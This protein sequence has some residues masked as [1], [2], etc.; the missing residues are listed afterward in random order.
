MT[1]KTV[2][3]KKEDHIATITMNRPEVYNALDHTLFEDLLGALKEVNADDDV[4]VVILTGAGKAFCSG[5]DLKSKSEGGDALLPNTAIDEGVRYIRHFPQAITRGI[6]QLE[7]PTIAMI[8]GVAVA[9]GFDWVLAC[10]LR[11]ASTNAKFMNAFIRMALFPNTGATWLLPRAIGLTKAFELLY[12]GDWLSAEE[13]NKLGLFNKL[14]APE[15]LEKETMALARK[16]AKQAP[17]PMRMMKRQT[18]QGLETSFDVIL[19]L[20]GDAE[21]ICVKTEDHKA[22]LAAFRAKKEPEFKGK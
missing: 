14:V 2:L 3:L 18:W 17:I 1:G 16:I 5:V 13:A 7:K 4:R 21:M 12:T 20:A 10:D 6:I 9:D 11:V 15:D 22:A 19:D 8:N